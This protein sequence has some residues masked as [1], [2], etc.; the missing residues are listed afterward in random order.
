MNLPQPK[1]RLRSLFIYIIAMYKK[2]PNY[3]DIIVGVAVNRFLQEY[4]DLSGNQ[5]VVLKAQNDP[6][7]LQQI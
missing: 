5:Y 3:R 6:E 2:V 4:C 1:V 7:P